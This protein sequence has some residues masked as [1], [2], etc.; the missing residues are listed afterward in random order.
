MH[1]ESLIA[2]APL[3]DQRAGKWR[4]V[5][6]VALLA[7]HGVLAV[8]PSGHHSPAYDETAHLTAGTSYWA[9]GDF[10]LQPE[11]GNLPQRWIAL[12]GWLIGGHSFPELDDERWRSSDVWSLGDEYFHDRGNDLSRLLFEG[13]AAVAVLGVCLCGLIYVWSRRMFGRGGA[14][15]SLILAVFSPTLLAHA[16]LM[17]SDTCLVLFL[18]LALAGVA[19]L[20]CRITAP[21][22]LLVGVVVAGAILSKTSGFLLLPIAALVWIVRLLHRA[23][24]MIRWRG[25]DRVVT[26][27]PGRLAWVGGS[28]LVAGLLAWGLVWA[29]YGFQYS[30]P[31]QEDG[32]RVTYFKLKSLKRATSQLGASGDLLRW[33]GERRLLPE[34]LLFG[35]AFAMEHAKHRR[36]FL[37]GEYS[38]RGWPQY[39]PFTFVAKTPW[40]LYGILLAAL[41]GGVLLIRGR[42]P[43]GPSSW[44]VVRAGCITLGSLVVVFLPVT[45]TSHLNIGHRHLL[46]LYPA[47]FVCA[48]AAVHWLRPQVSGIPRVLVAL[49]WG[50]FVFESAKASPHYL[51]Y[52]QPWMREQAHH[53][54]VDSNLDWG[55][56]LPVLV[57]WQKESPDL[58]RPLFLDYFGKGRPDAYGLEFRSLRD[59]TSEG[60]LQEFLPGWYAVSATALQSVYGDFPGPWNQQYETGYQTS[61]QALPS[62]RARFDSHPQQQSRDP[63]VRQFLRS[64][65]Q[66]RLARLRA[67]LRSRPPEERAG[68]SI[69]LYHLS[70]DELEAALDGEP[71][72]LEAQSWMEREMGRSSLGN[73]TPSEN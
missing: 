67:Y 24:L 9:E 50:S 52:F 12:P 71:V 28:W 13:R 63:Q 41:L 29:A 2:R 59:F 48:G 16:G 5:F 30:P 40:P 8:L 32:E 73:A 15:L 11:N 53:C 6:V 57:E 70:V 45:L 3:T 54:L 21:R 47:L 34:P 27:F 58:A 44:T 37:K 35:T 4:R 46:P 61:R 64:Y 17:T 33:V 1:A 20:S 25:V 43:P 55:Q 22:V 10:R 51:G 18:F 7:L 42:A 66:L 23:P 69:L 26:R 62:V 14:M 60:A 31:R 38:L 19:A 68:P 39:L 65:A 56:D 49:L 72:E 36:A